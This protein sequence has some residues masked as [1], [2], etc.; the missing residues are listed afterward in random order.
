LSRK[1]AINWSNT[2]RVSY[3]ILKMKLNDEEKAKLTQPE[4]RDMTGKEK[5]ASET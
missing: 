5:E 3:L 1:R 2:E 4:E